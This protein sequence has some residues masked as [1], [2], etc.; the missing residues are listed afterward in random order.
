MCDTPIGTTR[1]SPAK[2]WNGEEVDVF[3]GGGEGVLAHSEAILVFPKV[4]VD[5]GVYAVL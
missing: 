3:G 1:W 4:V 2:K 5:F